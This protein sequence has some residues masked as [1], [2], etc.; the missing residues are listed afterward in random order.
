M[1]QLLITTLSALSLLALIGCGSSKSS[2]DG[3]GAAAQ[4]STSPTSP[5]GNETAMA[6]CSKDTSSL[7]DSQIHLQQYVDAYGQAR[8]DYVRVQIST[9]PQAWQSGNW[10]MLIYRWTAAVDGSTSIDSSPLAFQFEKKVSGNYQLIANTTYSVFNWEETV[11]MGQY[12][13]IPTGTPQAFYG[14]TNLVVNLK[15]G[16][17]SFQALRVVLKLNGVVQKQM[18]ALIPTFAA[19]PSRY[20]ADARHPGVLQSLHPMK[21]K[22]GQNWTQANYYEFAKAFCF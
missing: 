17:N 13:D 19:D 15:D 6:I 18:D 7:S 16:S 20:A 12:A 11:Q 1:T 14:A 4:A 2:T 5:T 22:L 3:F 10:D 8:A 21:E 9:A